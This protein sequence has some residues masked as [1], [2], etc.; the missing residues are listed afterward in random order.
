MYRMALTIMMAWYDRV[1]FTRETSTM[2][3]Q[4][5]FGFGRIEW[6]FGDASCAKLFITR[7]CMRCDTLPL[8]FFG[9]VCIVACCIS[10]IVQISLFLC[11]FPHGKK[12]RTKVNRELYQQQQPSNKKHIGNWNR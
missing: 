6:F 1:S 3:M 10:C 11:I 9:F 4:N 8:R 5:L 2:H 7:L 12:V